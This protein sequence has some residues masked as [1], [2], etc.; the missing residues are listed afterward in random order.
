MGV[1]KAARQFGIPKTT[2]KERIKKEDGIKQYRL[3]KCFFVKTSSEKGKT[4]SVIV[5]CHAEGMFLPPYSI[6]KGKNK[7][8]EFLEGMPPGYQISMSEKSAYIN[9]SIFKDCLEFHFLPRKPAG[10]VWPYFSYQ[11]CENTGIL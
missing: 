5:S 7:K 6:F 8:K 11:F 4:I 1:N 9:A 2:L 3:K 10:K